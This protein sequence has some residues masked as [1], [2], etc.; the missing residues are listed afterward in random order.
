MDT[1]GSLLLFA[2]L[3]FVMMRFGCGAHMNHGRR[4]HGHPD[5]RAHSGPAK[6]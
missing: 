5:D 6:S 2:V 3:F 4:G 1:F